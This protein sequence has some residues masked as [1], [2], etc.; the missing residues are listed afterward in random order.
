MEL[1]V[2][3]GH[4]SP[5]H[6]TDPQKTRVYAT[7]ILDVDCGISRIDGL[8]WLAARRGDVVTHKVA[9]LA[10]RVRAGDAHAYAEC[11]S[12]IRPRRDEVDALARA[13]VEAL[14]P[15]CL[16]AIARLRRS[17]VRVVVVS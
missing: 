11:L 6:S 9:A 10:Q 3:S 13:Y 17:G 1:I 4:R 12:V 7:V 5:V 14:A 2:E 15:D 16:D 8:A